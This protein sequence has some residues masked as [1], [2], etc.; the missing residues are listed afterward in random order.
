MISYE[1]VVD[2]VVLGRVR[3]LFS[4]N[5]GVYCTFEEKRAPGV[6]EM[7]IWRSE[8]AHNVVL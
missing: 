4:V 6:V 3:V 1:F 2:G 7:Q 5:S 8:E